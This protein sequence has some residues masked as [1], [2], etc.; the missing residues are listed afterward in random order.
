MADEPYVEAV[1]KRLTPLV[2]N[3]LKPIRRQLKKL[4]ERAQSLEDMDFQDQLNRLNER[5]IEISDAVL[6]SQ[7]ATANL[8]VSFCRELYHG[9]LITQFRER[10][11]LKT[12]LV[13]DAAA[14]K[15]EI[16]SSK[17]PLITSYIFA[18]QWLNTLLKLGAKGVRY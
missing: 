3:K 11:D 8:Q 14:A 15:K 4:T 10:K 18:N 2:Q 1:Q 6:E 7:Q 12:Q 5:I 13:I 16:E 17:T 9:I